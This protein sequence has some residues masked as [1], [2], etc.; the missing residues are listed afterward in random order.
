MQEGFAPRTC[1][2]ETRLLTCSD[3]TQDC[4]V[5]KALSDDKRLEWLQATLVVR[6]KLVTLARAS[7]AFGHAADGQ[8]V[9]DAG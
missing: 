5:G 4:A 2:L 6:H 8:A 9:F 7:A 3:D 1:L